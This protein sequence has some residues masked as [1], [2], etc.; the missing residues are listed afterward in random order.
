V[1]IQGLLKNG[2]DIA[3]VFSVEKIDK[4]FARRG[5]QRAFVVEISELKIAEPEIDDGSGVFF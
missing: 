5:D 2:S 3:C 4:V 1:K